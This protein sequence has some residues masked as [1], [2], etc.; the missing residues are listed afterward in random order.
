MSDN[1][2]GPGGLKRKWDNPPD[3]PTKPD[4]RTIL[5]TD[6]VP[7]AGP[8]NPVTASSVPE[9]ES[10]DTGSPYGVRKQAENWWLSSRVITNPKRRGESE[11]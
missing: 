6:D 9:A 2:P 5:T 3:A 1:T 10:Q 4:T 11:K 7:E 8:H